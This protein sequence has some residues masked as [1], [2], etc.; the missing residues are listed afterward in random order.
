MKK[1]DV[2][3]QGQMATGI[4]VALPGAPLVLVHAKNGFV[5]CGYLNIETANKLGV[6]AGMVRGVATVSDLLDAPLVA[7]STLAESKGV[8][9]GMTGRDALTFFL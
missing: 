7:V 3:L 5:M 1:I 8:R 4:E 9:L 6:A 2:P